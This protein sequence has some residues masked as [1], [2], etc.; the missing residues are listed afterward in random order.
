M[1]VLF[2]IVFF[3]LALGVKAQEFGIPVEEL[4]LE[5]QTIYNQSRNAGDR[6]TDLNIVYTNGKVSEIDYTYFNIYDIGLR[7]SVTI[8]HRYI[9]KD[10]KYYKHVAEYL[11]TDFEDLMRGL[12][13]TSTND[14]HVYN[15]YFTHDWS[16]YSRVVMSNRRIAAIETKVVER[17]EFTD[18]FWKELTEM[19]EKLAISE[20]NHQLK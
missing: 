12:A 5:C 4:K 16:L 7:K 15:M 19:K 1:K 17:S 20:A 2:L 9:I 8:I 18:G 10:G 6:N 13:R 3:S 14:N 11:D